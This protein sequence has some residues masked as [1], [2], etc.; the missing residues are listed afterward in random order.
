MLSS[1]RISLSTKTPKRR[2][3]DRLSGFKQPQESK[4]ILSYDHTMKNIGVDT[5]NNLLFSNM[6]FAI[7]GFLSEE[8]KFLSTEI[9]SRG[10]AIL[11]T[12]MLPH[13]K[14]PWYIIA[15][16]AGSVKP[17]SRCDMGIYVTDFWVECC[18]E[19]E[20]LC[21]I[22]SEFFYSPL[23][24]PVP[25]SGFETVVMSVTGIE[26]IEREHIGRI[27]KLLG[28]TYTEALTRK[29]THLIA[30]WPSS[31]T[32]QKVKKAEEWNLHVITKEWL[33]KCC[34]MGYAVSVEKF[35]ARDYRSPSVTTTE[36]EP[37]SFTSNPSRHLRSNSKMKH[38]SSPLA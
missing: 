33:A 2:V 30:N 9:M 22:D 38:Q 34:Q 5:S 11:E 24:N 23:K 27:V 35:R 21:R 28:G 29:N 18:I 31:A 19:G 15:P 6:D 26:G 17:S 8:M 12:Y 25:L 13:R 7:V 20:T 37:Q 16:L 1:Q 14:S 36:K 3:F 10:G 32:S 4:T